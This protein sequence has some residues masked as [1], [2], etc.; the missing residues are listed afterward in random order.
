MAWRQDL[1]AYPYRHQINADDCCGIS[2]S[3]DRNRC[4]I[5]IVV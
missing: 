5:Q 2:H 3:R 1:V 4:G